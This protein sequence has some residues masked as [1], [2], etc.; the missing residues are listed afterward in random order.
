M[1]F[2][3]LIDA[4]Y[5]DD[6]PAAFVS[7]ASDWK[8]EKFSTKLEYPSVNTYRTRGRERVKERGEGRRERE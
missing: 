5:R 3:R 1:K 7:V 6:S 8:P 4:G 2:A